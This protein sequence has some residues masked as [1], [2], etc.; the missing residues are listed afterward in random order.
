MPYVRSKRYP[1]LFK[2]AASKRWWCFV[3]NPNGGR[4]LRTST[5]LTDE[6]AAHA[7]YLELLR[8]ETTATVGPQAD[9]SSDQE[10]RTV[11]IALQDRIDWLTVGRESRDPTRKKLAADTIDFYVG[12]SR[13]LVRVLGEKTLLS[14]LG[15]KKIREYIAIRTKEGAKGRTIGYELTTLSLAM[16]MARRDG[17]N[18]PL[19][20]DIKPSDFV[21]TY[22]PR[23]RWL[24]R[25][26]AP[27][28]L[29][30]LPEN[31]AI[32]VAF[33]LATGATFPSEVMR[34]RREDI[35]AKTY[36]VY[37]RGTKRETRD[38]RFIVPSDRRDYLDY[39][40]K[41]APKA[42]LLFTH[43]GNA[44]RDL[45]AAT[46]YLSMC[47]DCREGKRIVWS[48]AT[49]ERP[50]DCRACAKTPLF[51]KLC[52]TDLRRTFAKWLVLA[53]VPYE[54][55][56]PLMGHKDDRML[57]QVYGKR[58]ATDVAPLV[59]LA[60]ERG[61]SPGYHPHGGKSGRPGRRAS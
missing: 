7:R 34:A 20:E 49:P 58:S 2:P 8:G 56:Y 12:K 42:G 27:R 21:T 50:S 13:Q 41:R 10:E 6:R 45:L 53:G 18:C 36:E 43:W 11:A 55:A 61:L 23:T 37:I 30:E 26:E 1:E 25:E 33:I 15:Q 28:L 40:L 5:G 48:K 22:V 16:K 38:R 31:R 46:V 3:P 14:E 52:P 57:K 17:V 32:L 35:D 51:A 44:R 54:L 19:F 24:T 60:L 29:E 47:K 39:V 9:P 59:E 4:A